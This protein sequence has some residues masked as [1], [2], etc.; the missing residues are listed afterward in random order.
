M[1]SIVTIDEGTLLLLGIVGGRCFTSFCSE[2][3]SP[4][5]T[6]ELSSY[7]VSGMRFRS[8]KTRHNKAIRFDCLTDE[9]ID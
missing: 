4:P 3:S 5:L 7:H 2:E 6:C 8:A 1:C 9:L